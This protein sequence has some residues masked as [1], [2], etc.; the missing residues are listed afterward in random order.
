VKIYFLINTLRSGGAQQALASILENFSNLNKSIYLIVINKK[1]KNDTK[2]INKNIKV[3]YLN[4]NINNFIPVVSKLLTIFKKNKPKYIVSTG[5][6]QTVI[7]SRLISIIKSIKHISWIQFDYENSIP[8]SF[9]KKI[10]WH[11]FFKR[12]DFVDY[13]IILISKY[14]IN[15][16]HYNIGWNKKKFLIIP[17]TYSSK[18]LMKFYK[19]QNS[20]KIIFSP[21]RLDYDKNHLKIIDS[22]SILKNKIKNLKCIFIGEKGNAYNDIKKKIKKLNLSKIIKI[23]KFKQSSNFI[24]MLANSYL[25]LLLSKKEPFGVIALETIFLKKNFLISR[26]TGFKDIIGN[27]KTRNIV[28]NYDNKNEIYKKILDIYKKPLTINEK[29]KFYIRITKNFESKIVFNQWLKIFK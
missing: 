19:K 21:G 17:N 12:F 6:A 3:I 15:R 7:Y 23:K 16:Y 5:N 28:K 1:E 26:S 11:I 18:Y 13:K 14:L 10:L 24:K 2:I 25:V 4:E 9:L 22:I 8:K 27:L 29:N 20:N